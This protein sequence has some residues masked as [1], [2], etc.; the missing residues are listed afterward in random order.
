MPKALDLLINDFTEAATKHYASTLKGDSRATN[1]YAKK[2]SIAYRE[3]TVYGSV[4]REA[5][6]SLICSPVL[7]VA[8]MASVYS[9][10]FS[11]AAAL[12]RLHEISEEKSLLG[13]EAKHAIERWL[14]GSWNLE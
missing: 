7:E 14:D 8:A 2:V 12:A 9:L 11:N 5:L 13:F 4:G 10:K 3:I 1:T 6:A